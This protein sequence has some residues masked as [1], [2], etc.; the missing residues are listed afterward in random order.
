MSSLFRLAVQK[1]GRLHDRTLNLLRDCDIEFPS[2]RDSLRVAAF[3]LP[4][5]LLLVRDDDIPEYIKDDVVNAGIVGSNVLSEQ[6][7]EFPIVE[8]LGF[9]RCRLSIAA[10]KG[11]NIK[12]PYDLNGTKIATSHPRTLKNYIESQNIKA[13]IYELSGS[14]EMAPSLGLADL[15]CDL[16]STGSTLLSNGLEERFTIFES[17]ALFVAKEPKSLESEKLLQQLLLRI[18]SVRRA[19]HTKYILLNAP[20]AALESIIKL[21]PGVKSPTV[22]PLA[23]EGWSSIHS[24][25]AVDKFWDVI[26]QLQGAGA[27][28]ILVMPIEKIIA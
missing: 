18:R 4:L 8:R 26:Q 12:V 19:A 13:E 10:P 24:V 28:G 27:E 15:V 11:N 23:E 16:V 6:G 17:E 21:L 5:E 25:V 7:L 14:V 2:M 3:N 9:G 22:M 20:N 1:S